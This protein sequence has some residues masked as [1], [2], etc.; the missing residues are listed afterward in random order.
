MRIEADL[1][2]CVG[3][4]MCARTLAT[5][6]A[7]RPEDGTVVVLDETPPPELHDLVAEA[8]ALCPSGALS[9][10]G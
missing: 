2:V 4:G 9:T 10:T 7:Q 5:V 8:V 6:F 3:A 1:D